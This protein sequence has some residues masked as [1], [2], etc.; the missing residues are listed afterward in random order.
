LNE[1]GDQCKIC[2]RS[3]EEISSWT[4]YTDGERQAIIDSLP[5]R[6]S[7]LMTQFDQGKD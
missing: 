4:L 1:A 7:A 5:Q 3:L 2:L 6:R